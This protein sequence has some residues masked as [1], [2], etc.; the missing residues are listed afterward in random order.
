MWKT[1]EKVAGI[2]NLPL[3]KVAGITQKNARELFRIIH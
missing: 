3:E 1:A 2:F